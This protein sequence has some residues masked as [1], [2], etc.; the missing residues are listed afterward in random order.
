MSANT[1]TQAAFGLS[2]TKLLDNR[3]KEL[4]TCHLVYSNHLEVEFAHALTKVPVSCE[5][6]GI[7]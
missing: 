5:A 2:E 1:L 4:V 7:V 3:T 6:H